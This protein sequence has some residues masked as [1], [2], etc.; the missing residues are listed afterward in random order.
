MAVAVVVSFTPSF[1]AL[2]PTTGGDRCLREEVGGPG[3]EHAIPKDLDA[4][5]GDGRLALRRSPPPSA[6]SGKDSDA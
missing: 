3:D 6:E 5:G 4:F 2:L 1:L